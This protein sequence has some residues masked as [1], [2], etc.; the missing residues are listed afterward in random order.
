MICK[1]ESFFRKLYF[2]AFLIFDPNNLIF[3]V[4]KLWENSKPWWKWVTKKDL[5]RMRNTRNDN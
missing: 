2:R 3:Q 1:I 4:N 5:A